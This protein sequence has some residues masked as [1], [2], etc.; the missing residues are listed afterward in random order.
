MLFDIEEESENKLNFTNQVTIDLIKKVVEW[1]RRRRR[2]KDYEFRFMLDLAENKKELTARN[3]K[4]ALINIEKV[5][6]YGFRE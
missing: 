5:K 4:L 2:L 3:K 6:K 1:D